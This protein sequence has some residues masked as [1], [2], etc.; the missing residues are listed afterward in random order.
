ML[1]EEGW[2]AVVPELEWDAWRS[3]L[4]NN[5]TAGNVSAYSVPFSLG[6]AMLRMNENGAAY[7]RNYVGVLLTC[8]MGVLYKRA[9]AVLG[10]L[11]AAGV[12]LAAKHVAPFISKTKM[13]TTLR[14]LLENAILFLVATI[15]TLSGAL[16]AIVFAA[17][18]GAFFCIVHVVM[19]TPPSVAASLANRSQQPIHR[20]PQPI[21]LR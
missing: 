21:Q 6:E 2:S 14:T 9:F 7:F 3:F 18:I 8:A 11:G 10:L 17:A 1:A 13:T 19:R 12:G 16:G 20:S 4:H 5:M 15:L